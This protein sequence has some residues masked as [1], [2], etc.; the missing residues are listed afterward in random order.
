M[1]PKRLVG[2]RLFSSLS[3]KELETLAAMTTEIEVAEGADLVAQG[4]LAHEFFVI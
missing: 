2:V 3:K 1:D 4:A